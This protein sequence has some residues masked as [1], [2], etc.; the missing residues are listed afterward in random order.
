M[1]LVVNHTESKH[2]QMDGRLL[3][4]LSYQWISRPAV[5]MTES[6]RQYNLLATK[7]LITRPT[8]RPC[9]S[10][11]WHVGPRPP[12]STHAAACA[13][14]LTS[15]GWV[16]DS[17]C[18]LW[19]HHTGRKPQNVSSTAICSSSA[20]ADSLLLACTHIHTHTRTDPHTHTRTHAFCGPPQHVSPVWGYGPV[21][22]QKKEAFFKIMLKK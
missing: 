14:Q 5:N 7:Q 21:D 6:E 20:P 4:S 12:M 15:A 10:C 16:T 13:R 9:M 18:R 11:V 2:T 3:V 17:L 1:F 19:C 22:F 8:S